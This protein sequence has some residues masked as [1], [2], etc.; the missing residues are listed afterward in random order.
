[1]SDLAYRRTHTKC[2]ENIVLT[3]NTSQATVEITMYSDSEYA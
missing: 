3:S 2:I 1:M